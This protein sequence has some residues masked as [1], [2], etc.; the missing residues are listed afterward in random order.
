[1]KPVWFIRLSCRQF[2]AMTK[3]LSKPEKLIDQ[4]TPAIVYYTGAQGFYRVLPNGKKSNP[5]FVVD[6]EFDDDGAVIESKSRKVIFHH[7]LLY[8][9]DELHNRGQ[10]LIDTWRAIGYDCLIIWEDE[11]ADLDQLAA[12]IKK[13]IGELIGWKMREKDLDQV[14]ARVTEFIGWE[15]WE[16]QVMADEDNVENYVGLLEQYCAIQRLDLPEYE[17]PVQEDGP[18]HAPRWT[19]SVKFGGTTYTT[20]P[21]Q[22]SKQEAKQMAAKQI[23]KSIKLEVLVSGI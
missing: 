7:G 21:I 11:L 18:P 9:L 10:D 14:M 17:E 19:M 5:D 6:P 20:S 2:I 15:A 16:S 1:M 22:G 4:L 3:Y 23:L 13:S 8:H 12:N